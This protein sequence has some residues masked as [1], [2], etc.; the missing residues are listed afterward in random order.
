MYVIWG[1]SC[2]LLKD[3]STAKNLSRKAIKIDKKSA[4]AHY[5]LGLCYVVEKNNDLAINEYKTLKEID[6][7]LADELF[8]II[9]EK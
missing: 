9:F 6:K 8:E 5:L 7:D 2:F 3:Y 4:M 1:R